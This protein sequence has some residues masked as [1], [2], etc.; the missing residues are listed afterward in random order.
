MEKK[1]LITI[2][3]SCNN[4]CIIC[5]N[6]GRNYTDKSTLEIKELLRQNKD[7]YNAVELTGGEPTIRKD[8]FSLMRAARDFG[9]KRIEISSNLRLFSYKK[10]AEKAVDCGL[11]SVTTTIFGPES[12]HNATTRTPNSFNQT[13]DGY[14]NLKELGV[15]TSIN[16]VISNTNVDKI[17]ENRDIILG[18][19]PIS[20]ML[21]D[22]IPDGF[23]RDNYK[24]LA[25]RVGKLSKALN[26][27]FSNSHNFPYTTVYDYPFCVV[28]QK[29]RESNNINVKNIVDREGEGDISAENV[30]Y[31]DM[32]RTKKTKKGYTDYHKVKVFACK[33]CK[34]KKKCPGFW[35]DYIIFFG[36]EEIK[37]IAIKNNC[38]V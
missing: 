13:I 27:F 3:F 24:I 17:E 25:V 4:N 1:L 12:I 20:I 9:F 34:F 5:S 37:N 33:L 38:L 8:I 2:G 16:T 30:G 7:I 31:G 19:D 11:K 21:L 29:I 28:P 14:N 6:R 32:K 18:L 15:T 36:E 23:G 35:E 26:K 10:F 22:L